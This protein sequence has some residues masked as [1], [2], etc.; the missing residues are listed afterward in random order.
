VD[1]DAPADRG[2]DPAGRRRRGPRPARTLPVPLPGAV[3]ARRRPVG[4]RARAAGAA[5]ADAG[6]GERARARRA[7]QPPRR[8]DD[9]GAGGRPG[10]VRG[11]AL[12]VSHDRRFL[13]AMATRVWEVDG[14]P[15]DRLRGRLGLLP[16][17]ARRSAREAAPRRGRPRTE[18]AAGRRRPRRSAPMPRRRRRRRRRSPWRLRRDLERW[19]AR[20]PAWR[21]SSPPRRRR[22][23][24][25]CGR[26]RRAGDGGARWAE[27]GRRHD[28]LEAELL[29]AMASW[30]AA[31]SALA[32]KTGG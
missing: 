29:A 23:R 8:R 6:R 20:S 32:A 21:P 9:R 5:Q 4:R 1:G 31:A 7:D 26:R 19:E 18:G 12:L 13:E 2:A 24:R 22:W 14:G 25:G 10:R 27:L 3:Q 11:H 28:A 15:R 17:Q 30:E 16:A